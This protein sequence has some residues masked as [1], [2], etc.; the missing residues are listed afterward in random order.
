[1]SE[2][3]TCCCR[4]HM[5]HVHEQR[6]PLQILPRVGQQLMPPFSHMAVLNIFITYWMSFRH[7]HASVALPPH[8]PLPPVSGFSDSSIIALSVAV[9]AVAIIAVVLA[10]YMWGVNKKSRSARHVIPANESTTT[11]A[12]RPATTERPPLPKSLS[13][14]TLQPQVACT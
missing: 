4:T 5:L 13:R 12:V 14:S 10:A 8:P 9:P 2:P 1:M 11:I 7:G 6:Y 3:E